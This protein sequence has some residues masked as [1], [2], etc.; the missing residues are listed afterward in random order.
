MPGLKLRR[1]LMSLICQRYLK[2]NANV[3]MLRC[4]EC[5]TMNV[6]IFVPPELH[7]RINMCYTK[8]DEDFARFTKLYQTLRRYVAYYME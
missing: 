4:D 7:M 5:F 3:K 1:T 6:L 2:Y 8:P